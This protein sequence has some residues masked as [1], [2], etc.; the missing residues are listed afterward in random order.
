MWIEDETSIK[1]KLELVKKYNLAGAG[2]WEKD[3]EKEDIWAEIK[4]Q[5]EN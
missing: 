3:R 2:F 4:Q 5:L 1:N